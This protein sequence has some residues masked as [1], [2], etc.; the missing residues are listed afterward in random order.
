MGENEISLDNDLLES[1]QQDASMTFGDDAGAVKKA[2]SD[3]LK[4]MKKALPDWSLEPP[5]TFL[6]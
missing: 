4:A 3:S 5:E 6:A 2:K 1:I